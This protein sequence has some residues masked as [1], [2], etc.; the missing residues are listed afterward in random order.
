M[1]RNGIVRVPKSWYDASVDAYEIGSG[2][3]GGTATL[4]LP[5]A[6]LPYPK[7]MPKLNTIYPSGTVPLKF[8][9]G[10]L[11]PGVAGSTSTKTKGGYTIGIVGGMSLKSAAIT[12]LH[13]LR[14][15]VQHIGDEVVK[16]AHGTF[17]RPSLA[18]TATLRVT[19]KLAKAGKAHGVDPY[20]SSASEWQPWVGSTSDSIMRTLRKAGKLTVEQVNSVIRSGIMGSSFY[21]KTAPGTRRELM[22]QVYTEVQRQLYDAGAIVPA[23]VVAKLGASLPALAAP[24]A[25]KAPK[26]APPQTAHP[27]PPTEAQVAAHYSPKVTAG[28]TVRAWVGPSGT[29]HQ[30]RWMPEDEKNLIRS[31]G[32]KKAPKANPR[33]RKTRATSCGCAACASLPAWEREGH[34]QRNPRR[35]ASQPASRNPASPLTFESTGPAFEGGSEWWINLGDKV[36]GTL[37]R[38]RPTRNLRGARTRGSARDMDALFEWSGDIGGEHF[39]IPDGATL[40]EA[41]NLARAAYA[42]KNPR[43]R[44]NP[45]G[46]GVGYGVAALIGAAGFVAGAYAESSLGLTQQF[47]GRK[48]AAPA[49]A[50]RVLTT[51]AEWVSE[52]GKRPNQREYSRMIRGFMYYILTEKNL[53]G[54]RGT[55]AYLDRGDGTR[56]KGPDG[57]T[58]NTL[59]AAK[60]AAEADHRGTR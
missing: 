44:K 9:V 1:R 18:A 6:D 59:A 20:L 53:A 11:G 54:R 56:I 30:L 16:K 31:F 51:D 29:V 50:P 3:G 28:E 40:T 33:T 39:A 45:G 55:I 36:V 32:W 46:A 25:P 49:P 14:H 2:H 42:R 37:R 26:A 35:N 24:K 5:V 34:S 43:A 8:T 60:K 27:T 7:L 10:S 15:L 52:E 21:Q 58:F 12:I 22:G 13:E 38:D 47:K 41:K 57:D 48:A 4:M 23:N 19:K 17:G